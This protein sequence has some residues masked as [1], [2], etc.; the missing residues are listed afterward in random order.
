MTTTTAVHPLVLVVE[1]N[2]DGR[3]TLCKLLTLCG[4]Q[5]ESASDG[6]EGVMRG[7]TLRPDAA[8]VDIGLPILDGFDVAR[9]IR[10][11][12]G[13]SVL[14]IAHTAWSDSETR[15]RAD[16]AGFDYFLVKPCD[17]EA[18]L[19][20]LHGEASGRATDRLDSPS[21]EDF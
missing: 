14:L 12:L 19:R 1:D 7:L 6:A 4:F 16:E 2:A 18:L 17:F 3:E 20:M 9:E 13:S 8:V 11:S 5:T 15:R 10:R 21:S